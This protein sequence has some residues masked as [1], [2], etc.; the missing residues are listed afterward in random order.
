MRFHTIITEFRN[1]LSNSSEV[2]LMESDIEIFYA[3]LNNFDFRFTLFS[4]YYQKYITNLSHLKPQE[5]DGILNLDFLKI[6]TAVN[7]LKPT[8]PFAIFVHNLKYKYKL[9][10]TFFI[11]REK[12]QNHKKLNPPEVLANKISKFDASKKWISVPIAKNQCKPDCGC[13]E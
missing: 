3:K 12:K 10:S 7:K 6:A 5:E 9:T 11:S 8:K 2:G 4:S 1:K 13:S